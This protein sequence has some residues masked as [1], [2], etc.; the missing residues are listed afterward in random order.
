MNRIT[1]PQGR[2]IAETNDVYRTDDP[3]HLSYHEL[4]RKRGRMGGQVKVKVRYGKYSSPWFDYLMVS[5][6][7]ME[8]ILGGTDWQVEKYI[9]SQGP[10][11][12][13]IIDKK[14]K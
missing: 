14:K 6:G 8:N 13:T 3:D 12:I 7:E 1:S 9:E 4:N 2:I 5:K 10:G 11:Y